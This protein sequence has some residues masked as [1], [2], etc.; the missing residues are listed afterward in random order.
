MIF[1]EPELSNEEYRKL[2]EDTLGGYTPH[3]QHN[4]IVC[5]YDEKTVCVFSYF[6]YGVDTMFLHYCWFANGVKIKRLKYWN[7]FFEYSK[8]KFKRIMGVIDSQ[9][10]SALIWALKTGFEIT[11][12]R[13]ERN[14]NLIIEIVKDL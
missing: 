1:Y 8:E 5:K 7:G 12:I 11:G 4:I 13:Q 6:P 3:V 14:K 9:N 2:V 10:K